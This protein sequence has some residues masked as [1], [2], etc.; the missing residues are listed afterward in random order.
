V[1]P[2]PTCSALAA[3]A[4]ATLSAAMPEV[5]FAAEL[6]PSGGLFDFVGARAM[7]TSAGTAGTSST[8]ALFV[9]PG[10]MGVG[11]GYVAETLLVNERRGGST[12]SRYLGAMVVDAVSAPVATSAAYF[13]SME[14]DNKGHLFFLGFSGPIA[15]KLHLGVQGRYLKLGGLEPIDKLAGKEPINAVTADAGLNW[16]ASGLVTVG[17]AGFN[18]IPTG[19]PASLP[20]S[21]GAGLAVGSDTSVRVMAD[22]RGTFLPGSRIANRY[23]AGVG[24]LVGG[25]TALRIGWMRDELLHS[26]WWSAG[27][28]LIGSDGFSIDV[29]YKQSIDVAGAREMALSLRYF[30][31][32]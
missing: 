22:W 6:P 23:A 17:L 18:L 32:Q 21:M 13:S 30:P 9:N 15:E 20:Q 7:G 12:T 5:A 11:N 10:A 3:L 25:M 24:A 2:R 27:A 31:P 1:P 4:A 19:H 28:G 16:N 14:G 8:E 29:G 26:S